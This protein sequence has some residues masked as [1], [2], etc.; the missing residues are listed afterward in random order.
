ML[1]LDFMNEDLAPCLF[2]KQLGKDV[3][4]VTIYVDDVNIFGTSNL[5]SQTIK[6]LQATFEMKDLGEPKYFLGLQFDHLPNGI[7]ISQT[8]YTKKIVT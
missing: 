2:L 4:I 6:K 3:V 5:T 8:T 7:F 1:A